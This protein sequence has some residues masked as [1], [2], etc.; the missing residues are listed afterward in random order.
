M[1]A[2]VLST[3]S[4]IILLIA[5]G[6]ALKAKGFVA[7]SYW[8]GAERI[9]YYVLL[10]SLFFY[11]LATADL[12]DVPVREM[13]WVLLL[14]TGLSALLLYVFRNRVAKDGPAFTSVFQGGVRFNN[15][16]GVTVAAGLFGSTGVAMAAVANA[17]IVPTV[18]I[19]CV[20]VFAKHAHSN[21][22]I[23]SIAKSIATNPLLV[24]CL[25]GVAAYLSGLSL[26]DY[27]APM[28][29]SLGQAD[30]PLGLL[31]VGA[32]LSVESIKLQVRPIVFSSVFKFF[33]MPL[34]TYGACRA[35]GFGGQA[36]LVAVI[37]QSLPTASSSY[38]MARQ[39][40][41]DAPLMSNIV[42][43]QTVLSAFTL[44]VVIAIGLTL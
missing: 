29:K 42:A 43:I 6:Y 37:F 13:I 14:S 5:L 10:P 19:L 40:G 20:L 15:F 22:S 36:A 9:G 33:V 23:K 3:T 4:P 8:Q 35:L 34:A 11:S 31:C 27:L 30:S 41:G 24:S 32:A 17:V 16:I 26:P 38:V 18:N 12:K 28:I 2:L 44:P 21:S 25:L 7:D 1:I 39:L